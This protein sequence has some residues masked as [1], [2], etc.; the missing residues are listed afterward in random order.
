[1][2]LLYT[3]II[4][5]LFGFGL[6]GQNYTRD[7]GMQFGNEVSVVYRQFYK[8]DMAL[9]LFAGYRDRG[10]RIGGRREFFKPALTTYSENFAFY[11]GYGVHAGFSYTNKHNV[12]N[13]EYRYDWK[14]SPIFGMHGVLG[15]EYHFPEV[16]LLVSM[17]IK[18]YYEFSL[19]KIF[20]MKIVDVSFMLK[21]RF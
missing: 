1:M 15:L 18:P 2:K 9:E 7:V 3:L 21:Y 4:L 13:R 20:S 5:V 16:P 12:L 14:F 19:Y 6:S 10:L 8:E 11:Y 17:D